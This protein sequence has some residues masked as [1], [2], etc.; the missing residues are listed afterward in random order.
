MNIIEKIKYLR[1]VK[2]NHGNIRIYKLN[3]KNKKYDIFLGKKGR[4]MGLYVYYIRGH[5]RIMSEQED[6]I[7]SEINIAFARHRKEKIKKV[8]ECL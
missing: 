4:R 8:L 7:I 6:V 3:H 5:Y 1:D 2:H